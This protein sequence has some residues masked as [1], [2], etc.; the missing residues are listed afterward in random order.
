MSTDEPQV[1]NLVHA[2][3]GAIQVNQTSCSTVGC[4]YSAAHCACPCPCVPVVADVLSNAKLPS[5][6]TAVG[7]LQSSFD[8]GSDAL[9]VNVPEPAS[10]AAYQPS[11]SR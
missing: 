2:L 11:W 10:V 3:A 1:S 4:P 8:G 7:V 6:L 5:P 9:S